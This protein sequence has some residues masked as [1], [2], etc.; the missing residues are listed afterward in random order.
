MQDNESLSFL[1]RS[2]QPIWILKPQYE[3]KSGPSVDNRT[4]TYIYVAEVGRTI[5]CKIWRRRQIRNKQWYTRGIWTDCQEEPRNDLQEAESPD[6]MRKS[7][8]LEHTS[9]WYV[10]G[11]LKLV[12]VY[13]FMMWIWVKS[14]RTYILGN[15]FKFYEKKNTCIKENAGGI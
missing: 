9:D 10:G 2:S 3:V 4:H 5:R 12:C 7:R 8:K 15:R 14:W 11:G 6:G 13:F 1:L